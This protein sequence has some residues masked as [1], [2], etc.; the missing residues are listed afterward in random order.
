MEEEEAEMLQ[1]NNKGDYGLENWHTLAL[2]LHVVT[3][4]LFVSGN[5][6]LFCAIMVP[7]FV[8]GGRNSATPIYY[9]K[10]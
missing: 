1:A 6:A 2:Y 9:N 8:V 5:V 3:S 10:K 7:V 4:F